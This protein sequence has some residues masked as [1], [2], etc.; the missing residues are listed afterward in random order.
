MDKSLKRL[1]GVF[2]FSILST[3]ILF[4]AAAPVA[5]ANVTATVISEQY[6]FGSVGYGGNYLNVSVSA[7]VDPS[8]TN[9]IAWHDQTMPTI[10]SS[11]EYVGSYSWLGTDD[12]FYLTIAKS[13]GGSSGPTLMDYNGSYGTASGPQAV[14]YGSAADAPNVERWNFSQTH[15]TF[16]EAGPFTSFFDAQGAGDYTFDFAFWDGWSGS[17]GIPKIYLL[18]DAE[19]S[20]I[21]APSALILGSIGMGCISWFRRRR[22]L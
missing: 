21:P 17:Y 13:G 10:V 14:I 22:T 3:V 18:V 19:A 6:W 16:D 4:S 15:T 11:Q 8:I 2:R 20:V 5:H 12:Y 9:W 1:Q 7:Y